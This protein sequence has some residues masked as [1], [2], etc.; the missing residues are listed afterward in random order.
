[1]SQVASKSGLLHNTELAIL[2]SLIRMGDKATN[3]E[4]EQVGTNSI[5]VSRSKLYTWSHD[6]ENSKSRC[7]FQCN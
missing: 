5:D 7:A 3:L 1:M 6:I 4:M 2:L